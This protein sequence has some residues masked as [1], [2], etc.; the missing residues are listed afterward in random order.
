MR[1]WLMALLYVAGVILAFIYR[2][3]ILGWLREDHNLLLS[4]GAATLLAFF[5]SYP[6]RLSSLYTDMPTEV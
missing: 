6:I 5:L 1:K 2:N 4:I 3:E